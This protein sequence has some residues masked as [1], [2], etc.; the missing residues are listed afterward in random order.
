MNRT[1]NDFFEAFKQLESLCQQIYGRSPDNRLS[2]TLYLERMRENQ[3]RG[4]LRISRWDYQYKRLKECRNKRNNLIH[5]RQDNYTDPCFPDDVDF[6]IS[7]RE[8]ILQG[9]DPLAQ[10]GRLGQ[11]Q[12]RPAP[13]RTVIDTDDY[14]DKSSNMLVFVLCA[15]IALGFVIF[16]GLIMLLTFGTL[17]GWDF[18]SFFSSF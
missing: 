15:L 17:E 4:R 16:M 2:V 9:T 7:F 13:R 5:P 10:L 8:S 14:E 11:P 12:P 18:G 3:N 6:L 1:E